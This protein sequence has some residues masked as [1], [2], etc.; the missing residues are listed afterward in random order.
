MGARSRKAKLAV[1]EKASPS[2]AT[3]P[4]MQAK[5]AKNSMSVNVFLA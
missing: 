5:Q 2:S 4:D 1:L 3:L